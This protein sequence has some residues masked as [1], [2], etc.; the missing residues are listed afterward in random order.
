MRSLILILLSFMTI[1]LNA[2][3]V[4]INTANPQ[5]QLHLRSDS[6][7]IAI[8]LDNKKNAQNGFNY[9]TMNMIPT[10]ISEVVNNPS[11]KNWTNLNHN[12]LVNSDDNRQNGP[13]LEISPDWANG[14]KVQFAPTSTIPSNAQ[15]TDIKLNAEWRRFG[16][17]AGTYAFALNL[18]KAGNNQNLLQF[19]TQFIS[20]STDLISNISYTDLINPITPDMVNLSDIMLLFAPQLSYIN[21][22]S[23]LEIDRL[24][25]EIEYKLPAT[26]GTNVFWSAGTKEGEFK[27]T[28][29]PNLNSNE[30][31]TIDETGTTQLKGLRISKNAGPGKVLTSNDEGKAFWAEIPQQDFDF[32][33]LNKEDTAYYAAGPVQINNKA[34]DPAIIFDKGASKINNSINLLETN[35]RLL[36]V[37]IDANDDQTNEQFNIYK[38]ST[39]AHSQNPAVRFN[40]G[41]N[42]SWI[43]GGG[44]LGVGTDTPQQKLSTIGTVRAANDTTETEFIEMRHGGNHALINTVGDGKL[45][46][47]HDGVQKMTIQDD[48]KVGIGTINP[49]E[50]LST[51]GTIRAAFD[52][53]ENEYV[54]FKHAGFNALINTVGDGKLI[55]Q[56]DGVQKMTIVDDGKVGIG[57]LNPEE[58]LDVTGAIKIGN[59]T[60]VLPQGGTIRWNGTDYLGHNGNAWKSFTKPSDNDG[61]TRIDL[62]ASP[63]DDIIRF[64]S[65]GNS[66]WSIKNHQLRSSNQ[67]IAIGNNTLNNLTSG[68]NNIAIGNNSLREN[69]IGGNN[70]GIGYSAL[71]N[72]SNKFG[73]IA[74]GDSTLWQNSIGATLSYEASDNIG[75]GLKSLYNIKKGYRNIAIG[76]NTLK[77]N[78]DGYNNIA[79]GDNALL[80]DQT[81]YDN[82]VIGERAGF[83]MTTGNDNTF[84]GTLCAADITSGIQNTGIGSISLA[85]THGDYNTGVGASSNSL[86]G[87]RSNSAGIGYNAE[88]D[89]SNKIRIGNESVIQIGGQVGWSILSDGRIKDRVEENVPGLNFIEKLRPITFHYDIKKQ[90]TLLNQVDDNNWEG[91]FDIE[92][93]SFSGFIAQEVAL[94]ALESNYSFSGVIT[95]KDETNQLYALRMES[96]VVPLVQAAKEL[97]IENKYLKSQVINLKDDTTKLENELR[98]QQI[99]IALLQKENDDFKYDLS[100]MKEEIKEM[101]KAQKQK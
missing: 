38:D 75:I 92:N 71:L 39:E 28:N 22:L 40:L 78:T 30:Y 42:N 5:E 94:A 21:G 61:D 18:I 95:P 29:S 56:H 86:D 43:N 8:R 90:M 2:Q 80:S 3:N 27:I 53:S 9:F 82:V 46:I 88:P 67:N 45:I 41:G 33:W 64:I 79:I 66:I 12:L 72:N 52:D 49:Q 89:G 91:K 65:G 47:Q 20:N 23:R 100:V 96:F 35:N 48:G 60:N 81:G 17:Y 24:W 62:E 99:K 63:D 19:E 59:T 16:T 50:E 68:I 74:I 93:I 54:E 1:Y 4:G 31:L 13:Q 77:A 37:I 101:I 25:L 83:S 58:Q 73:N 26:N 69:E 15:I 84:I 70:I 14:I 11:Y 76:N 51:I 44:N 57:T 97:N 34:G 55:F 85:D 7:K 36:N 6:T 10:S 87:T 98:E 32:I